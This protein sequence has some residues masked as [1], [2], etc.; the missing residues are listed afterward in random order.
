MK[1]LFVVE[2]ISDKEKKITT[3]T[4]KIGD[5]ICYSNIVT[6]IDR[7]IRD[8]SFGIIKKIDGDN[9]T[10][11]SFYVDSDEINIAVEDYFLE[12]IRLATKD[13]IEFLHKKFR[14]TLRKLSSIED[15]LI[16]AKVKLNSPLLTSDF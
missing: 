12:D 9:F 8:G 7:K 16:I 1:D 10:V 6:D 4:L 3:T 14:N 2:D 11:K 15:E 13:E 5:V